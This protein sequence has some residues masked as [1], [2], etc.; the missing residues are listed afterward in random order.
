V[1]RTDEEL[2]A[3]A[4]HTAA[5]LGYPPGL[6]ASVT[7]R[8]PQARVL[9]SDPAYARGGGLVVVIDPDTGGV[10]RC[11]RAQADIWTRQLLWRSPA[12]PVAG[13]RGATRSQR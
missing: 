10:L 8:A 12:E 1:A 11:D 13:P 6:E 7:T 2:I 9:L 4:L 5:T 3:T